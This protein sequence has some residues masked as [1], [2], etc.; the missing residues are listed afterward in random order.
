MLLRRR[1]KPT[2]VPGVGARQDE[3]GHHLV[4]F[5]DQL[6][7]RQV[8]IR[9]PFQQHADAL[10]HTPWAL[11]L[12]EDDRVVV[13]R[14]RG[15]DLGQLVKVA[16]VDRVEEPLHDRL[17]VLQAHAPSSVRLPRTFSCPGHG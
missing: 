12:H 5:G 14:V 13:D 8:Q 16:A 6:L 1:R 4:A 11:G 15:D 7:G 17:V 3:P 10:L 2:V 9:E